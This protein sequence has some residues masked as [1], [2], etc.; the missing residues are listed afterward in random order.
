MFFFLWLMVHHFLVSPHIIIKKSLQ[1]NMICM[2]RSNSL[3][4]F[5]EQFPKMITLIIF[6]TIFSEII[7]INLQI[8]YSMDFLWFDAVICSKIYITLLTFHVS[9]LP[10]ISLME[11][12]EGFDVVQV[13]E[14]F[15]RVHLSLSVSLSLSVCIYIYIYGGVIVGN[16]HSGQC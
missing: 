4:Y 16:R 15:K 6:V 3:E 2:Y 14:K 5:I 8:F 13:I 1:I 9:V 12:L 11:S 7:P 10:K